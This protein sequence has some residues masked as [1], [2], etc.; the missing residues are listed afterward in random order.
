MSDSRVNLCPG[1]TG[2]RTIAEIV[3]GVES[4]GDLGRFE[5]E[6]LTPEEEDE[7]FRILKDA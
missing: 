1:P 7:F 6:D 2:P 5:I 4:M 3:R